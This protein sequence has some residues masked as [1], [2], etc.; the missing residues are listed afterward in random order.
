L[1][2]SFVADGSLVK[3]IYN[4]PSKLLQ[5]TGDA[6]LQE[7][8]DYILLEDVYVFLGD[9]AFVKK[10]QFTFSGDSNLLKTDSDTFTGDANLVQT[11]Y[12]RPF[13]LLQENGDVILQENDGHLLLED[14]YIFSGNA[15]FTKTIGGDFTGDAALVGYTDDEPVLL[16]AESIV[17]SIGSYNIVSSSST[18]KTVTSVSSYSIISVADTSNIVP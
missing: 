15:S 17:A 7:N 9:A 12:N 1:S 11:L 14:L 18:S 5:E 13:D 10:F 8:D 3:T 2:D 4:E 6:I 16:G